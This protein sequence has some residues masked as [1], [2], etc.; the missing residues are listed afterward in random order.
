MKSA[1]KAY[2]VS[3]PTVISKILYF[4]NSDA[5][6]SIYCTC[7]AYNVIESLSIAFMN[8]YYK[9]TVHILKTLILHLWIRVYSEVGIIVGVRKRYK[10]LTIFLCL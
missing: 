1:N 2:I 10:C 6:C 9:P 3:L 8:K 5:W 7:C 4:V